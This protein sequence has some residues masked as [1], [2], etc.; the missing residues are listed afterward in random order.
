[1]PLRIIYSSFTI[2]FLFLS[3]GLSAT[4]FD[5]E[6]EPKILFGKV[7]PAD[8]DLSAHK[9]DTTADAVIIANNGSAR[10][11]I[12]KEQVT[13]LQ[14][15]V[16]KRI[17]ILS[18][19]GKK[20]ANNSIKLLGSN[21]IGK[22]SGYTHILKDGEVSS[23]KMGKKDFFYDNQQE[24]LSVVK[25]TI[26]KVEVGAIIELEY[27]YLSDYY[28]YIPDWLFQ[29]KYPVLSSSFEFVHPRLMTYYIIPQMN[30]P[31]NSFHNSATKKPNDPFL[32]KR[33]TVKDL[34]AYLPEPLTYADDKFI[35][36]LSFEK[37]SG[38]RAN[39]DDFCDNTISTLEWYKPFFNSHNFFNTYIRKRKGESKTQLAQRIYYKIRNQFKCKNSNSV[40]PELVPRQIVRNKK[41]NSTDIN[42]F[43][44]SCLK[45]FG[46]RTS[47]VLINTRNNGKPIMDVPILSKLN[48][49]ACYLKIDGQVLFLDAS[50]PYYKF[51]VL[52]PFCYNGFAHIVDEKHIAVN[53]SANNI[54][55]IQQTT[56]TYTLDTVNN[57]I[58]SSTKKE[59]GEYAS[60]LVRKTLRKQTIEE[61]EKKHKV[62]KQDENG[63]DSFYLKQN[64]TDTFLYQL[65][66]YSSQELEKFG[67]EYSI[68]L[69][70]KYTS[71]K[72][73]NAL[74]AKNR[75]YPIELPYAKYYVYSSELE[76]PSGFKV[77]ETPESAIIELPD[78]KGSFNYF[79]EK[80][81]EKVSI[82]T[83]LKLNKSVF[84]PHEFSELKKFYATISSLNENAIIISK[85]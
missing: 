64:E 32:L 65:H 20:L 58:V 47:P 51:G 82:S 4:D 18:E 54:K 22:F 16:T 12:A 85:K 33:W 78:N 6:T 13:T 73:D 26:P 19:N 44:F 42:L 15:K 48:H 76:I 11:G 67:E 69:E 79:V 35:C 49:V 36:K 21:R 61:F 14:H 41:T 68:R 25:F 3:L 83:I 45:H 46:F 66:S 37:S 2:L 71:E 52:P 24:G 60:M 81:E 72:L 38:Y 84:K 40:K 55:E 75:K 50:K 17:K 59:L 63:L 39:W 56:T 29:D 74:K 30:V 31:F 1:M 57:K 5:N 34:P 70:K 28:F 43:L 53:L 23:Y 7:T 8:F 10:M 27:T 62:T 9:F 80:T 77:V